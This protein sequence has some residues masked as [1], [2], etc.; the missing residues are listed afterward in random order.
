MVQ[1][2]N[3]LTHADMPPIPTNGVQSHDEVNLQFQMVWHQDRLEI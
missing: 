2:S 3:R 1:S